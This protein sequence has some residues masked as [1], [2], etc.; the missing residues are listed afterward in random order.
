MSTAEEHRIRKLGSLTIIFNLTH[1]KK[2]K[3]KEK[4]S[5]KEAK[6]PTQ[7]DA[8]ILPDHQLHC[9]YIPFEWAAACIYNVPRSSPGSAER[10][11]RASNVMV[12]VQQWVVAE[13]GR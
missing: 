5:Q 9:L 2:K 3:R 11:E 6:N 10:G 13:R 1:L 8:Y 4:K 7:A 12:T